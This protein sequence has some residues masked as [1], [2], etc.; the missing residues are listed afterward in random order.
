MSAKIEWTIPMLIKS[1]N[2]VNWKELKLVGG[3]N[4]Y[5][6]AENYKNQH[7]ECVGYDC[8]QADWRWV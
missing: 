2:G 1:E 7:K 3:G 5:E 6:V 4:K 8:S